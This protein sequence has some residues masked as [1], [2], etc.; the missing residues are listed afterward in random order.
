MIQSQQRF[1]PP[2]RISKHTY[3]SCGAHLLYNQGGWYD[4]EVSKASVQISTGQI[5]AVAELCASFQYARRIPQHIIA[6]PEHAR[7]L[8]LTY[9]RVNKDYGVGAASWL[10]ELSNAVI[11]RNV[12]YVQ[13]D[14]D[15][16]VVYE[17][18]RSPDRADAPLLNDDTP[19][20]SELSDRRSVY[21]YLGSVGSFNY[22]HWLTDDL[23]RLTAIEH[24]RALYPRRKVRVVIPSYGD[25]PEAVAAPWNE[26]RRTA[27]QRF[28]H[29]FFGSDVRVVLLDTYQ[30]CRLD[31]LFYASPISYHPILKSPAALRAVARRF[32][33]FFRSRPR[34]RL[35]R[36]FVTRQSTRGRA[37]E[38]VD[39]VARAFEQIGFTII[40]TERLSVRSQAEIFSSAKVVA[41][42]MGAA[43]ANTLFCSEGTR[44]IHFAPEGWL[45]PYYWDL[46]NVCGHE[47][48]PCYGASVPSDG[49]LHMSS[50]RMREDDIRQSL[51][52]AQ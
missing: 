24:L 50:F 43:M 3:V 40:N 6:T 1:E 26:T 49:P 35:T 31:N 47:Y 42:I 13:S 17:T 27:I 37:L 8:T 38:N 25:G 41:G 30:P 21:F 51:Q 10:F 22:G 11:Y 48:I 7:D 36:L 23:G 2:P 28:C 9:E 12:L 52:L 16:Y 20:H 29:R 39:A 45:E 5:R 44:V 46:A 18:H 14:T 32:R 34:G 33:P 15:R 19:I 4:A